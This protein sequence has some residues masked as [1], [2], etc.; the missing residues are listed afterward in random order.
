MS[1]PAP[2]FNLP[3][4]DLSTLEGHG[5]ALV[6]FGEA[7][8]RDT[9]ADEQRPE[10]TRLV[11]LSVAGSEYS[12]A[13]LAARLGVPTAYITRLPDNPYGWMVRD[14]ARANGVDTSAFAWAD[15]AEPI[16]RYIFELGRSPRPDMGWYQR[17]YSAGSRLGRGMVDWG[18]V[19]RDSRI[20]HTSGITFGLAAHS[21]YSHNPWLEALE[22]AL[23]AKPAACALGLDFNYRATLWSEEECRRVLEPLL[24]QAVDCLITSVYDMARHFGIGCGRWSAADILANRPE[25]LEDDDLRAFGAEVIRHFGL[26]QVAI[27]LRAAENTL[28]HTWESAAMDAEGHFFRSPCPRPMII[29]DRLGGGDAWCG[30]F[31]YGLLT[32]GSPV[33][34]LAKGVMV[35]DAAARLKQTLMFDLPMMNRSDLQTVLAADAA[36]VGHQTIR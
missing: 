29:A 26:K 1:G 31:Y 36:G 25:R 32:G 6:T 21:G 35:G 12:I 13:T 11:H 15:K 16:G 22:E 3:Q 19:L 18:R 14:L 27:T 7:M 34:G 20:L 24:H 17:M 28:H 4:D 5:P 2:T 10:A 8:L 33:D 30:G 9:P 23:Q